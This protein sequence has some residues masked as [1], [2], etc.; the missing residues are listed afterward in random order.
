GGRD[1]R[2]GGL[3]PGRKES[4]PAGSRQSHGGHIR[5]AL[6][7]IRGSPAREPAFAGQGGMNGSDATTAVPRTGL[8]VESLAGTADAGT[9]GPAAPP[10]AVSR[11]SILLGSLGFGVA[12]LLG[13]Q[14]LPPALGVPSYIIPT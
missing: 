6:A 5:P 10:G 11:L 12:L 3:Y 2:A 4:R 8:V 9:S 14:F 13:L 7:G 1:E